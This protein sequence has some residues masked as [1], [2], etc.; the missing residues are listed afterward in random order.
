MILLILWKLWFFGILMFEHLNYV[1]YHCTMKIKFILLA[2]LFSTTIANAQTVWNLD[3]SHSSVNF[4]ITHMVVSETVGNFKDFT[5]NIT[6]DKS[7]FSDLK[8]DFIIQT[9][10]IDTD[11]TKRDEHLRG[12]DFFEVEKYPTIIFKSTSLKKVSEKKYELEGNLTMKAVTKKVKWELNYNGS[13]TDKKGTRAGFKA[14]TFVNR[15]DYGVSFNKILDGG[16]LA[17]SEEVEIKVNIEINK[18]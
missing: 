7:D 5:A 10:S 6:A 14:T 11:D 3:K 15:K 1:F 18:K 8:V 16:G 12:D 2:I 13:L 17:L 4:S 9:K